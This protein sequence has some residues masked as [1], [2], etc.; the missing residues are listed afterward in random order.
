M[1]PEEP[2]QPVKAVEKPMQRT[3]REAADLQSDHPAV[4]VYDSHGRPRPKSNRHQWIGNGDWM[5]GK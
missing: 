4:T 2:K 3:L 1:K 5:R